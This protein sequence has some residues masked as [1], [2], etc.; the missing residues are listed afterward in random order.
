MTAGLLTLDLIKKKFQK[1]FQNSISRKHTSILKLSKFAKLAECPIFFLSLHPSTYIRVCNYTI[2]DAKGPRAAL[3][4]L[5]SFGVSLNC[6]AFFLKIF[7]KYAW[8]CC[9]CVLLVFLT[10]IFPSGFTLLKK[11]QSASTL[12]CTF[13]QRKIMYYIFHKLQTFILYNYVQQHY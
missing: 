13:Y 8:L 2:F 10:A 9:F 7:L 11:N 12:Y 3:G 6:F 1:M 5:L 4:L